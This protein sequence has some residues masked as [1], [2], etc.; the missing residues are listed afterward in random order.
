MAWYPAPVPSWPTSLTVTQGVRST[1]FCAATVREI[2]VPGLLQSLGERVGEA[3][4]PLDV[5]HIHEH[6]GV[7]ERAAEMIEEAAGVAG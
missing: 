6:P 7:A 1:A 5:V 2:G 4:T 3:L